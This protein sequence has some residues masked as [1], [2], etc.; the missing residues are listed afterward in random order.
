MN[1]AVLD[2][3]GFVHG[4][5]GFFGKELYA[6]LLAK[7][8]V[9]ILGNRVTKIVLGRNEEGAHHALAGTKLPYLRSFLDPSLVAELANVLAAEDVDLVHVNLSN[10]R[11]PRHVVNAV[12]SLGLPL[13]TTA[14]GWGYVCPTGWGVEFPTLKPCGNGIEGACLRSLW[15]LAQKAGESRIR[16]VSDGVS[17]YLTLRALAISSTAVVSPSRLLAQRIREVHGLSQVH[18]LPNPIPARLLDEKPSYGGGR[19]VSFLGRFVA[20]KGAHLLPKIASLLPDIR[21]HV[22]GSGAMEGFLRKNAERQPNLIVHG[23]VPTDEK[24]QI[25]RDSAAILMPSIYQEAFGYSTAEAFA[26]GKPVVGFALGGVREMID[27]SG[28]G[29]AVTPYDLPALVDRI[30]LLVEDEKLA[31][32]MGRKGRAWVEKHLTPEQYAKRLKEIYA[33]AA[34]GPRM[35]RP[36]VHE[37]AAET[38]G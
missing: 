21:V 32:E 20:E 9:E 34:E 6:E 31:M 7:L 22:M 38:R 10:P 27:D 4:R 11:Y 18:W 33:A 5:P 15:Y 17:Q 2:D 25:V 37:N 3:V 16:R 29:F 13:V 24:V 23:F 26:L 14:H 35:P 30:R 1:I 28:G 8:N 19:N 12:S 36:A